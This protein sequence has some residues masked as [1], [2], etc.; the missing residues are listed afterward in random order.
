MKIVIEVNMDNQAFQDNQA[1]LHEIVSQQ[2]PNNLKPG[3]EGVLKDSNG[4]K[5]GRWDIY[6]TYIN[7]E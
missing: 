2:I 7:L 6:E 3:D 5:V 4:N 1:E